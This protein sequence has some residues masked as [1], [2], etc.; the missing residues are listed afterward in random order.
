MVEKGPRE[1][2]NQAQRSPLIMG[3]EGSQSRSNRQVGECV[4]GC[5]TVGS[6]D[7]LSTALLVTD[8]L[9]RLTLKES[10]SQAPSVGSA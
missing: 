4:W 10:R 5:E 1:V 8:V 2:L 7:R 3:W 9:F 6:C